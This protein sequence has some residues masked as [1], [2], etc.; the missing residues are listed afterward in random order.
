VWVPTSEALVEKMFELAGLTPDDYVMDLGS[1]DGRMI[2]AAAKRGARGTG[3]EYNP[4]LVEYSRKLANEQ[5]V[6]DRAR[7]VQGDMYVADISKASV[8]ALFLLPENLRKLTPNFLNLRPGS[9]I[10]VNTF[11]IPD[12]TPDAVERIEQGCESWCEAKLYIVPAQVAGTWEVPQGSLVLQQEF[13]ELSGTMN[14]A[15]I[16]E[17]RMKGAEITFSAGGTRYTGRVDGKTMQLTA[18]GGRK[19][20]A[21]RRSAH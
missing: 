21:R 7:F 3:V 18:D 6:A 10:V 1:G 13:Q 11:G 8:L 5:G 14:G 16:A 20:T 19:I 4:D 9:R 2:L 12:W 15:P 17:G